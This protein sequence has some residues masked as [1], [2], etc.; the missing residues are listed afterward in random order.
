MGTPQQEQERELLELP[1]LA[2]RRELDE[3]LDRMTRIRDIS[4]D[5][6]QYA[7]RLEELRQ[8]FAP[9]KQEPGAAPKPGVALPQ[10]VAEL[11]RGYTRL[12]RELNSL[13]RTEQEKTAKLVAMQEGLVGQLLDVRAEL[14]E[15]KQQA[16]RQGFGRTAVFD[17]RVMPDDSTAY[18]D[19]PFA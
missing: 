1:H 2:L 19:D 3:C 8:T 14:H 9:I 16:V 4:R 17:Y 7:S 5:L 6:V 12:L 10:E 11:K 18:T 13:T 15:T